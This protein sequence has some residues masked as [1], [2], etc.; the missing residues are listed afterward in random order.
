MSALV[1]EA[2]AVSFTQ[3]RPRLFSIARRVLGS[4]DEADDVVQDAWVRWQET[5]RTRVRDAGAFLAATTM[6]LA[7]NVGQS[8][9][10]RRETYTDPPLLDA[11]DGSADPVLD[12]ER[13][14]EVS[15]ALLRLL[16]TLSP[17]E[18]AVYLLREAFD[19]PHR[20]IGE[21][22]GLSEA[23]A[24]QLVTRAR[25][26]LSGEHRRAVD[27]TEHQQLVDAFLTAAATGDLPAFERFLLGDA[28]ISAA[29]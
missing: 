23:N 15:G 7:L 25:R 24:R 17:T 10:V 8:A 29:A 22:L 3:A 1:S 19:Y 26:R 5:D 6:R 20:Q 14:T 16:E 9:R 11:V 12:A 28:S 2:D 27:A 13:R 18:R 21:V 4:P